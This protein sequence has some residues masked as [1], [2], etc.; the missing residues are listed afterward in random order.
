[1]N[2]APTALPLS[3][4]DM[5]RTPRDAVLREQNAAFLEELADRGAAVGCGVEVDANIFWGR[6]VGAATILVLVLYGGDIATGEHVGRG[7][8]IR[9]VHA[10]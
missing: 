3:D 2:R 6:K 1:M 4:G 8:R 5:H 10:V 7:E 9:I